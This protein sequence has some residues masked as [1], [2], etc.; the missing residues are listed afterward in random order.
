MEE[1]LLSYYWL[2]SI[3]Q[4]FILSNNKKIIVG[5]AGY[6]FFAQKTIFQRAE[7][8][9]DKKPVPANVLIAALPLSSE[10]ISFASQFTNLKLF[11]LVANNPATTNEIIIAKNIIPQ[12]NI[13]PTKITELKYKL[14]GKV[15]HQKVLGKCGMLLHPSLNKSPV[16]KK[17]NNKIG[18]ILLQYAHTRLKD[19]SKQMMQSIKNN[20]SLGFEQLLFEK[21]FESFGF[22]KFSR[23]LKQLAIDL[24]YA[25]ITKIYQNKQNKKPTDIILAYWLGKLNLF[26]NIPAS[27]RHNLDLI[28]LKNIWRGFEQKPYQDKLNTHM[29]NPK[30]HPVRR[31]I[32]MLQLINN[33]HQRGLLRSWLDV[34]RKMQTIPESSWQSPK[35]VQA[36]VLP[37]FEK[38]GYPNY[39]AQNL[40]GEDRIAI[41]MVNVILPFF[42]LWEKEFKVTPLSDVLFKLYHTFPGEKS[43]NN[44]VRYMERRLSIDPFQQFMKK[45]LAYSQGLIQMRKDLCLTFEDGCSE[46]MLYRWLEC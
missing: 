45:S 34:L 29:V 39:L 25:E 18:K 22:I 21:I 20:S 24:D 37:I 33:T 30:G 10:N 11:L 38:G 3:G 6:P 40:T 7:L 35:K 13:T 5:F 31:L 1:L 17:R 28:M 15:N 2:N 12:I 32:S 19:K 8:I 44:V 16:H 14:L 4:E 41:V 42:L 27:Q 26:E 46:C 36:L 43:N 23:H 9:V